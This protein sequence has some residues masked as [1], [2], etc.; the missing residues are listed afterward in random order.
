MIKGGVKKKGM[1]DERVDLS[2]YIY[3]FIGV[4]RYSFSM[5]HNRP[6]IDVL[7]IV[8]LSPCVMLLVIYASWKIREGAQK[9]REL[10]PA[11]VVSQ[12]AVKVFQQQ[13]KQT[14]EDDGEPDG[15]AICLEDYKSGDELRLL[16]CNHIF[17]TLCVDAWLTTQKKL[18]K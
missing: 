15:C 1:R 2:L 6:L 12:L 9:R 10:A 14:Q 18:V 13:E 7:I 16:P 3:V 8:I 5:Y 17:H 4:V 11:S